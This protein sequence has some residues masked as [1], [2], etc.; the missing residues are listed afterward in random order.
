MVPASRR[1][2]L[3]PYAWPPPAL[4][5]QQ[6]IEEM[7]LNEQHQGHQQG[8]ATS[9]GPLP[10]SPRGF[11]ANPAAPLDLEPAPQPGRELEENP[12]ASTSAAAGP[13]NAAEATSDA[14]G[15]TSAAATARETA[16]SLHGSAV[17]AASTSSAAANTA[18][19]AGSP[20]FQPSV[21]E[22]LAPGG[23]LGAQATAEPGTSA[24]A[25]SKVLSEVSLPTLDPAGVAGV[26]AQQPLGVQS[27]ASPEA[28]TTA[29]PGRSPV[30]H[31]LAVA[32]TNADGSS[33]QDDW[34]A[35]PDDWYPE[36]APSLGEPGYV[37]PTPREVRQIRSSLIQNMKLQE[38]EDVVARVE[39]E[40][41]EAD[42]RGVESVVEQ[43]DQLLLPK[44]VGDGVARMTCS[45]EGSKDQAFLTVYRFL[46]YHG[47]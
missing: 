20:S 43:A 17:A 16:S 10:A 7:E 38:L 29:A 23:S 47:S 8:P 3:T 18:D 22:G 21:A 14:Q 12:A 15:A 41:L 35:E 1:G 2:G 42:V 27:G 5:A 46:H 11:G 25:A 13:S 26:T 9:S 33:V 37:P 19:T 34:G 30:H 32:Q 40:A 24:A 36:Y 4:L 31:E 44:R 39:L 45:S 6:T 28:Q